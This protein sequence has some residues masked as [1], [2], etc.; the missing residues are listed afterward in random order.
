MLPS[1]TLGI[2]FLSCTL[3]AEIFNYEALSTPTQ[4]RLII[5]ISFISAL[6]TAATNNKK[7]WIKIKQAPPTPSQ[8][9]KKTI[10]AQALLII[11]LIPSG[12]AI[13]FE[14]LWPASIFVLEYAIILPGLLI[15]TKKYI[16]FAE[17][18]MPSGKDQYYHLGADL[19]KRKITNL[20]NHKELL[21]SWLVKIFFIPL[22]YTWTIISVEQ[23]LLHDWKPNPGNI[24]A[25]LFIFG[26][27]IDLIIASAGYI[28]SS[29]LLKNQT[30]STDKS[31]LG[32]LSCM[33]CYPPLLSLMLYIKEQTDSITWDTWL[34]PTD[35]I[36]WAWAALIVL[37]WVIYWFSTIAFG[38][39]FSNLS[40]RG[41]VDKGPYRFSKHPA[42]ISK[43][44]YWWL[45]TVPF[46]GA[47]TAIDFTTNILGLTF[48]S[49]IY[50]I[51][52]KT[53]EKH[54]MQFSEYRSYH[55]KMVKRNPFKRLKSLWIKN[56]EPPY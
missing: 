5:L 36:Y 52:A 49:L 26:L 12:L 19:L 15:F 14:Q 10:A 37:T 51:R 16:A 13:N 53:E 42:Y 7:N 22:M 9:K 45:H 47:E 56:Q 54:L 55:E 1:I 20:N 27:S 28:F 38:L 50:Y 44:I 34:T 41:L 29:R 21:L 11:L 4:A 48:V 18:R 2:T 32:W 43:N 46:I 31:W 35:P 30:I 33:I 3:A 17:E 6:Y 8:I 39:R 40:W 24:I 25:G 23:L